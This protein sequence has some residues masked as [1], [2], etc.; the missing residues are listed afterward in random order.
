MDLLR[1][2]CEIHKWRHNATVRGTGKDSSYAHENQNLRSTINLNSKQVPEFA[3]SLGLFLPS[4]L[5]N[6]MYTA[7]FLVSSSEGQFE[8]QY[9]LKILDTLL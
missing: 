6:F 7:C 5:H 9:S 8:L 2:V 1:S 3:N 4:Q